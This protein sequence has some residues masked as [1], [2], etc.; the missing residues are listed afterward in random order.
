LVADHRE[1]RDAGYAPDGCAALSSAA[2]SQSVARR[3]IRAA[4]AAPSGPQMPG[5]R[6][7]ELEAQFIYPVAPTRNIPRHLDLRCRHVFQH[8]RRLGRAARGQWWRRREAGPI[9]RSSLPAF[10]QLFAA[11]EK[12]RVVSASRDHRH[13]LVAVAHQ[14]GHSDPDQ[15]SRCQPN[16][17]YFNPGKSAKPL[18]VPGRSGSLVELRPPWKRGGLRG[19]PSAPGRSPAFIGGALVSSYHGR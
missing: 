4:G 15:E 6:S 1:Y 8:R 7:P 17:H 5:P 12:V 11:L 2:S 16:G 10:C 9:Q 19:G 3:R 14:F 18:I 13:Q